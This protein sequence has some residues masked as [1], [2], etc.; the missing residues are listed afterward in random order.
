[1]NPTASPTWCEISSRQPEPLAHRASRCRGAVGAWRGTRRPIT[2][3][4]T[5]EL[6][7]CEVEVAAGLTEAE[8]RPCSRPVRFTRGIVTF[9]ARRTR[10][11]RH[12]ERHSNPLSRLDAG[13][14][15]ADVDNFRRDLV[16]YRERSGEDA[17]CRKP[18]WGRSGRPLVDEQQPARDRVPVRGNPAIR[19]CRVPRKPVASLCPAVSLG[20]SADECGIE[21]RALERRAPGPSI[22]S[23]T[24]SRVDHR[25]RRSMR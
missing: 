17:E 18:H 12:L 1:M 19:A 16:P 22:S 15:G 21:R 7:M 14:A 11:A 9:G 24:S 2:C 20:V 6:E 10:S 3:W 8:R 5:G 4:P 23:A 13:D 25:K